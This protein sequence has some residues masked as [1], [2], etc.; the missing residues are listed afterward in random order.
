MVTRELS[1]PYAS[2]GCF[3]CTIGNHVR[4][5]QGHDFELAPRYGE[6]LSVIF[7]GLVFSGGLPLMYVSLAVSFTAHYLV[8]KYELLKVRTCVLCQ[9]PGELYFQA[10]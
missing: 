2:N 1:A 6:H 10:F 5:V 4:Y 9:G 3:I 8:E 7:I